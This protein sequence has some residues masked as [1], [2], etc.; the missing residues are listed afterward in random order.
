M[1]AARVIE[2]PI[3]VVFDLLAALGKSSLWGPVLRQQKVQVL[4]EFPECVIKQCRL[5][6]SQRRRGEG[7]GSR[8]RGCGLARAREPDCPL[9]KD[10]EDCPGHGSLRAG[11]ALKGAR[12]C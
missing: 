12:G 1:L 9:A 7:Y 5:R 8:A 2:F 4:T 10:Q 3:S 6:G 11:L